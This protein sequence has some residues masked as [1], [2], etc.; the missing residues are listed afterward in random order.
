MLIERAPCALF[1]F[2]TK[3][4]DEYKLAVFKENLKVI[5]CVN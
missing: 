2:I 4:N 1:L 3:S 5:M